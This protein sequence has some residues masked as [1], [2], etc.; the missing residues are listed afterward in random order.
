MPIRLKTV[1]RNGGNEKN[2]CGCIFST[3]AIWLNNDG[4]MDYF[5]RPAI[6]PYCDAFY[7]AHLFEYWLVVSYRNHGKIG[8]RVVFKNGGDEARVLGRKSPM[9]IMHLELVGHTAIDAETSTWH[10]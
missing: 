2:A 1:S 4:L 5:V 10:F 3:E 6:E 9:D 7:G 8:Y